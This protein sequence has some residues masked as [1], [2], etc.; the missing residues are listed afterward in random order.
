MSHT[1]V[2]WFTVTVSPRF[3]R[4]CLPIV[5]LVIHFMCACQIFS[6]TS[7]R[8]QYFH[9]AQPSRTNSRR[10]PERWVHSVL[11]VP[12]RTH[13]GC[14]VSPA[15]RSGAGWTPGSC[16]PPS[17]SDRC[18]SGPGC[19]KGKRGGNNIYVNVCDE[20]QV[21]FLGS[22]S[23]CNV[24]FVIANCKMSRIWK[25]KCCL[26]TWLSLDAGCQRR[27][28]RWV[29]QRWTLFSVGSEEEPQTSLCFS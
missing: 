6:S 23:I 21:L 17:P 8:Q 12:R 11:G 3:C 24:C 2:L 27:G 18:G 29:L 14:D 26:C 25:S 19:W 20:T 22:S 13:W 16:C 1:S 10:G 9:T 5:M 15:S 4:V 28:L 7:S